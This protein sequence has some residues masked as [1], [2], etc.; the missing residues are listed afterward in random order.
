M[1]GLSPNERTNT[2]KRAKQI[3]GFVFYDGPS[4]LDGA[5]I[6]GIATGL[7]NARKK[8][9]DGANR[10]TGA[11]VQTYILR[12]DTLPSAALKAG[13]DVSICG[14]CKHRGGACYV[15]VEQGP[16]V[17][18]KAHARG[19]YPMRTLEEARALTAGLRVRVG[20]YGDPVAIPADAW[21]ALLADSAGHTGYTHQWNK[22]FARGYQDFCM[23]SCDTAEET[24]AARAQGWRTF[25]VVGKAD[26]HETIRTMGKTFLCPASKEAGM[27]L[28][29][30]D[31]LACDGNRSARHAHVAIPAH[32]AIHKVR[33]FENQLIQI[34]RA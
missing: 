11:M 22:A 33:A 32:G 13:Q 18:K 19:A 29:C 27:K 28:Q 9:A 5:P 12:A 34:G 2:M 23:A 15:R 8:H 10:K 7:N 24:R 21:R 16:T 20:T 26:Y 25:S 6:V 14:D 31:C 17:V 3:N 4:A 30:S 1:F